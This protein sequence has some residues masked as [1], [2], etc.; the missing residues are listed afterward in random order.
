MHELIH[1]NAPFLT[2]WA[3]T[4]IG[5]VALT[6]L[7]ERRIEA[8]AATRHVLLFGA[9]LMP[10]LLA[11][12]SL[13]DWRQAEA[14]GGSV[15]T[16]VGAV[17]AVAAEAP[18][19]RDVVC[20]LLA[21]WA[22]GAIVALLRTARETH[23]WRE[24][25]R[26]ALPVSDRA[27]PIDH[28]VEISSACREPGVAGIFDPTILL[29]AGEY[30]HA[31]TD[32]ELETVLTH[33]LEHV[34]R[35]DNLR[36][37][38]AQMVCTVFWFSPV[39]RLG[40]RRLV[41]LRERACD[42]AVL[43]RG[44]EPDSYL[45]ALAKS[46]TSSLQS[47]AVASMSRLQLRERME[48][49]MTLETQSSRGMS[50]A[51]RVAIVAVA[52]IVLTGFA[53]FAP[54]PV[55]LASSP[56]TA[57]AAEFSADVSVR[58]TANGQYLATIKFDAPDGPFTTVAVLQSVPDQRTVTSLHN[59]RFYKVVVNTNADS[60]GSANIE[61]RQGEEI[62]W[63]A[64][65]T[66]VAMP[67]IK[68]PAVVAEAE[69]GGKYQRIQPGITSP[70]VLS[71]IEPI[72]PASAKADRIAGIV[73]LEAMISE[74]GI[75]DDVRVL[76]PLPGGLDQAAVD[77]VKQWTFAPATVDGKPVP[78]IFNVTINFQLE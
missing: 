78:V 77:A 33:E 41:E 6:L 31:L 46:C 23:R 50:W 67:P 18:A 7:M 27:M 45:S 47:S 44:C 69:T 57:T 51:V 10:A 28:P 72:Y 21:L 25:R 32:D 62:V 73:I 9:M 20:A 53:L 42:A 1:A 14:G 43:A 48:S 71:R 5:L 61:V 12:L 29:P 35:H 66:F 3:L 59:G 8:P 52:G 4:G 30:L 70:K 16:E 54:S 40:R 55:L 74:T 24:A 17:Q 36:A 37:L 26:L 65:R 39:H 22:A 2:A 49:I 60:S 75:I 76:K 58:P 56:A 13:F 38:I 68:R 15:A 19:G 34:R 63:S 11:P 64:V